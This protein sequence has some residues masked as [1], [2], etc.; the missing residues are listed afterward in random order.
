MIIFNFCSTIP[1]W[2]LYSK[3][4]GTTQRELLSPCLPHQEVCQGNHPNL[5]DHFTEVQITLEKRRGSR[6]SIIIETRREKKINDDEET[7]QE[8]HCDSDNCKKFIDRV[9]AEF[10]PE[11]VVTIDHEMDDADQLSL[12]ETEHKLNMLFKQLNR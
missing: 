10:V 12:D 11:N 6:R 7:R 8:C 3:R 2:L 4:K 9:P 5:Q 1:L